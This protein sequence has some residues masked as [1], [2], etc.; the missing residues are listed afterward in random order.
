MA[1]KVISGGVTGLSYR[2]KD[3]LDADGGVATTD[4]FSLE[5]NSYADFGGKVVTVTRNPIS[6]TRQRKKGAIVD[7]DASGGFNHDFTQ[8]QLTRLMQAFFY[9]AAFETPTTAPLDSAAIPVTAVTEDVNDTYSVDNDPS[10][11]FIVGHLVLA[12]GFNNAGNNGVK[13]LSA[14]GAAS[15]TTTTAGLVDEAAPPAAAKLKVVGFQFASGDLTLDAQTDKIVLGCTAGDFTDLG[16]NP[17]QWI[18]IGGDAVGNQ[19]AGNVPGYARIGLDDEDITA[20]QLI[21]DKSTFTPVDDAGAGKTV[22][23]FFGDYIRNMTEAEVEAAGDFDRYIMD[24]ERTLGRDANGIQSGIL[25]DAFANALTYTQPLS[26]KVSVDLTFVALNE[27][28]RDG[29]E[30]LM[31]GTRQPALGEAAYDSS[32]CVYRSRMAIVDPATLNPSALF[33]HV[34]SIELTLENNVSAVKAQGSAG[35]IDTIEGDFAI[36]GSTT[37]Y[38]STVA[39][40]EAIRTYSDVTFDVIMAQRNAGYV[41]DI[42]LLGL[43]DGQLA[44]DKDAPITVPLGMGAFE[45]EGGYTASFTDFSYLPTAAMP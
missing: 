10:L 44:V 16:L 39:A 12:S 43:G 15:V 7:F 1:R 23:I 29:T 13:Y 40:V 41:F 21:L 28:F 8:H 6:R 17:G 33:A 45:N 18:F 25:V 4:W 20:T 22:Q 11:G 30:G 3:N 14:V 24:L 5:P 9:H 37:V 31:A 38:F 42:P 32:N 19:F 26:N 2:F 27:V 36:G 35:G 34:Q